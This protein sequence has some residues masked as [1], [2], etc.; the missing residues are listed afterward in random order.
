LEVVVRD[1]GMGIGQEFLP[2]VFERYRQADASTTRKYGGLGLGLSIVKQLIELH[3]GNVRVT[4]E[5]EGRGAT[6]VVSLPLA[7]VR[8]AGKREH[9]TTSPSPAFDCEQF[10]LNGVKV[11]IVDDE[12]DARQ[13]I[14]RMLVQCQAEV[15]V[16]ANA[17]EGLALLTSERPNVIVSD[18][19][20]PERDGYQLI[21]DVRKLPASQG[22]QT[23]AVALTAFARS[24]DRTRAMVAGYH[25]HISKPVEPQELLATVARLAGR[26]DNDQG[27]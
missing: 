8:M 12:P 9:P 4:S 21:R 20:M 5:G 16:A 3:G 18:I 14:K 10:N 6:F 22:G 11:L 26:I 25:M 27:E 17:A 23:P 24:E 7:P 1:T 15:I 13:L 2:H 19:G